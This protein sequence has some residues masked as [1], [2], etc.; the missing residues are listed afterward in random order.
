MN[1][2]KNNNSVTK[3]YERTIKGKLVRTYRN[4]LSRVSSILK[5][6]SHLY[7][8]LDILDK[9]EFYDWSL[10]NENYLRLFSN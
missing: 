2:K 4:M 6:K 7:Q 9:E 1:G 8:G 3:T 10:Q 5:K